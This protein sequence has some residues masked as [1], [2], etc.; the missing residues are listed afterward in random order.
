MPTVLTSQNGHIGYRN[1]LD[2]ARR[3]LERI[4]TAA[5]NLD[6]IEIDDVAF[7]DDV[8]SFF[9]ACWHVKDWVRHDPLV[10]Q[11]TKDAIKQQ[12]E[13]SRVLLM[14][15]DVCNGTKHLKLTTPRAG[16]ARYHSTESK[17][18]GGL[19]VSMDGWIDDGAG[20]HIS[21]KSLARQCIAEWERILQGHG[22][23]TAR[24]S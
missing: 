4:E 18:E 12:A 14:C 17:L 1:Q 10:P 16:G 5:S 22:L 2:R 23:A 6:F 21:A 15:H 8:W 13:R 7:Q 11:A 20:N 19:V 24:M 9:Q 3:M